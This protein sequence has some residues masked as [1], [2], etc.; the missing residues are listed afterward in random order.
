MQL[1]SATPADTTLRLGQSE[2]FR[3]GIVSV[4]ALG[5]DTGLLL[6][7]TYRLHQHYLFAASV[8]FIAGLLLNYVLSTCWVFRSRR[9]F[10]LHI[11]FVLFAV[12]G[13]LGLALTELLLYIFT[14]VFAVMLPVSKLLTAGVVF[15]W[16]FGVRKALLFTRHAEE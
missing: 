3:A 8:A 6:L 7:L 12:V 11:E 14:D 2:L 5:L 4:L 16:N 1:T 9:G 10:S 13:L 15:F